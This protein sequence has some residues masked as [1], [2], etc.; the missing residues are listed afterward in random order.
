[1]IRSGNGCYTGK[2]S[3]SL[4]ERTCEHADDARRME[5]DSHQVKHW[6]LDHPGE[7][8]PPKF[9]FRVIGSFKDAMSRAG[10]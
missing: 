5:R 2:W 6:F 10:K 8:D 1:M 3:R 4:Y 9:R 7:A